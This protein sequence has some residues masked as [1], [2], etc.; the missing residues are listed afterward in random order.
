MAS[1]ALHSLPALKKPA[2]HVPTVFPVAANVQ[3][4]TLVPQASQIQ[5]G[6]L[7]VDL[8]PKPALQRHLLVANL[9]FGVAVEV[10]SSSNSLFWAALQEL[11]AESVTSLARRQEA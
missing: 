6:V 5:S 3:V 2:L 11:Q 8:S 7:K 10:E 9:A 4:A 1:L